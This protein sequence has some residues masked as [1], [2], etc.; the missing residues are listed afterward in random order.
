MKTTNVTAQNE[1][2]DS[3]SRKGTCIEFFSAYQDMDLDRMIDL[4]TAEG[5]VEFVPLGIDYRGKIR[6]I[7]K[8]LWAGLMEAFPNLDNTI[9]HQRYDENEGS[10]TCTVNI[11]GTQK[12]EFAGIPSKENDFESEHIFI[13]RFDEA[14]KIEAIRIDWNHESFVK[15]LTA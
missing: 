11:F 13:F 3:L 15:Q 1:N 2:L 4:C 6:E 10:V 5:V 9:L 8:Q 14:G 7:G 12:N